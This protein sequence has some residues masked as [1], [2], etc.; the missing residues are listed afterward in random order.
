MS[1][2]KKK[3]H[4]KASS[5]AVP[6]KLA[7]KD[8]E[9]EL[10]RLQGELVALQILVAPHAIP[11]LVKFVAIVGVT[12]AACMGSYALVSRLNQRRSTSAHK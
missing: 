11:G 5:T 1:K 12:S 8:Y 3:K 4:D 2:H 10:A 9:A 7:R 6:G